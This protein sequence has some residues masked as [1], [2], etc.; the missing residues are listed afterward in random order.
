MEPRLNTMW[1]WPKLTA[2]PS[3]ILRLDTSKRLAAHNTPTLQYSLTGHD[4]QSDRL[5]IES[6]R[7]TFLQLNGRPIYKIN[8]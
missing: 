4:R 6:I 1:H 8:K 2:I 3:G 5:R 7:R